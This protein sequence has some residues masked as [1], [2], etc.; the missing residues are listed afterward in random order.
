MNK[1]AKLVI[2]VA[3][4]LIVGFLGSLFTTPYVKTWFATI[5]KPSFSPPNWIFAPVW[6]FLFILMGISLFLVWN[7]KSKNKKSAIILFGIQ[8][9]LNL[10]W[11]VL[12]FTLH[13]PL[14]SFIE[15]I[16]LWIFILLTIFSF[17]KIS[18]NSAYLLIPYLLWVSFASVLNFAIW[19]L[20]F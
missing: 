17:Y 18:K 13:N 5:I 1:I 11:S 4:P 12:F 14:A 7:S 6:T 20:N 19:K 16:F 15:I 2:S 10:T 3:I 8:L 9:F